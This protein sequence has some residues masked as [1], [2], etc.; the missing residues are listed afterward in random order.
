MT[1]RLDRG[2]LGREDLQLEEDLEQEL[3]GVLRWALDGLERLKKQEW[4]FTRSVAAEE[5]LA[6]LADMSSPVTAFVQE[7]CELD[8]ESLVTV[9]V[10]WTT[11]KL[12]AERN[13]VPK[14]SKQSFGRDLRAAHPQLRSRRTRE[15]ERRE[16]AYLG[17]RLNWRDPGAR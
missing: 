10:L 14:G 7:T 4:R 9:D 12:W 2:W 3:S 11:W 13:G 6:E 8:A 15:G 17:L 5:T 1:V 16:R